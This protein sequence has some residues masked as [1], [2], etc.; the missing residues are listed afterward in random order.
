M[1]GHKQ[2]HGPD[3][4]RAA[5]LPWPRRGGVAPDLP[6]IERAH[7]RAVGL[8]LD[9]DRLDSWHVGCL[10]LPAEGTPKWDGS[11]RDC[12][13]PIENRLLPGSP[14]IFS[15]PAPPARP[16]GQHQVLVVLSTRQVVADLDDLAMTEVSTAVIVVPAL[17]DGHGHRMRSWHG[18]LRHHAGAAVSDDPLIWDRE[19][20]AD[21][22]PPAQDGPRKPPHTPATDP[23]GTVIFVKPEPVM[24]IAPQLVL[25]GIVELDEP[26]E[27]TGG[28]M[29]TVHPVTTRAGPR[30]RL[31][32]HVGEQVDLGPLGHG[33][34]VDG[35][36][37]GIHRQGPQLVD[38]APPDDVPA[39]F[40][41]G[42]ADGN[43]VVDAVE[44]YEPRVA[45][46]DAHPVAVVPQRE[47]S[48]VGRARAAVR[49]LAD[50]DLSVP[51]PF[52]QPSRRIGVGLVARDEAA[53]AVLDVAPA[54]RA[55]A[56]VWRGEVQHA[57]AV[58]D[59]PGDTERLA[60]EHPTIGH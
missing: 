20:L 16:G 45:G 13:N 25:H 17:D 11:R 46:L 50:G 3:R 57:V 10:R 5:R 1:C 53:R 38:R 23:V 32:N 12:V 36:R 56:A 41:Q 39:F 28:I 48:A 59:G 33:R 52:P 15:R 27:P 40:E 18:R 8:A 54:L 26:D 43:L 44:A 30:A 47:A 29:D 2:P 22:H 31:P 55:D 24:V 19:G 58:V 35:C 37:R 42:H 21:A 60:A 9:L 7:V 4:D 34:R 49:S 14:S 6:G 51:R